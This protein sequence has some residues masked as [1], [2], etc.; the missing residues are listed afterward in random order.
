[1]A[2]PR[3]LPDGD[4]IVLHYMLANDCNLGSGTVVTDGSYTADPPLLKQDH[5][6]VEEYPDEGA[7]WE[8]RMAD[9]EMKLATGGL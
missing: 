8:K 3:G 1:M 2:W 4:L 5:C 7:V 9:T 6:D